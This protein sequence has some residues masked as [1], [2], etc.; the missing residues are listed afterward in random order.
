MSEFSFGERAIDSPSLR[1]E[2]QPLLRLVYMWMGFG[3]LVTSFVAVFVASS[4][5]LTNML[6]DNPALLFIALIA[7]VGLVIA[8]SAGIK[9][10]SA[11]TAATLFFVYAALTGFTL[12]LIFLV[13]PI[14]SI[15]TA[16]V[17][18]TALFGVMSVVGYTTQV[19]LTKYSTYFMMA[20]IGLVIALVVNM[21]LRSTGLDLLISM[22][23]VVLFTALTA[24]DT[25]KIK[26]IAS[27]PAIQADNNLTLKMAILGALTLYLDFINLFL[28]LLRLMGGSRR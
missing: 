7:E 19:D 6:L 11:N 8:I 5:T 12:S 20:L 10:F 26:R 24:Y 21:F 1:V 3:L 2:I 4:S 27:D 9:R 15:T 22:V 18:T 28:F 14:G 25:Q 17:T 13:Y 16:F 23:G